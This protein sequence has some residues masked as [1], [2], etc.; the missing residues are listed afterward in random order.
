MA[1]DKKQPKKKP[2][3]DVH[4]DGRA[5]DRISKEKDP[6]KRASLFKKLLGG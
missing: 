4:G 3:K 6:E 5:M 2:K 1:D